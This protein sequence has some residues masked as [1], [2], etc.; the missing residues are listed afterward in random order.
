MVT[1]TFRKILILITIQHLIFAFNT[2]AK[3]GEKEDSQAVGDESNSCIDCHIKLKGKL[4]SVVL[5]WQRSVHAKKGNKC[6]ICHGGNPNSSDKKLSKA[7]D[8]DFIGRPK[9]D[10]II[11]F[12]GRSECHSKAFYQ[13]KKSPHYQS[14]I[15][16]GDPNCTS[17]HG[18]HN[19]QKSSIHIISDKT[20]SGCHSV[21]Y[22]REIIDSIFKIENDINDIQKKI[23]YL[24]SENTDVKE[25]TNLHW[26]AIHLFHQLV[27]VFSRD[28]M[29]FT[30]KILDLEVQSLKS[31]L[32]TK[33]ALVKRLKLLYNLTI[34][35]IIII[36]VGFIIY[37]LWGNVRRRRKEN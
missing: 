16:S 17:C 32:D 21:E 5:E 13:F 25:L 26:M 2:Y 23:D 35:N 10:E 7:R 8:Y 1:G 9:K 14:V 27:H 37:I 4:R 20:C 34:I 6:H 31:A 28:E 36:S 19:I 12:C 22:S 24:A 11:N 18:K 33:I 15:D 3:N 29:E 30:K